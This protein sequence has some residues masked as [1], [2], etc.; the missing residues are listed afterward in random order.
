MILVGGVASDTM[1]PLAP[2]HHGCGA[3]RRVRLDVSL[4]RLASSHSETLWPFT[5]IGRT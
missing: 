4:R 3:C 5:Y 2:A 1:A